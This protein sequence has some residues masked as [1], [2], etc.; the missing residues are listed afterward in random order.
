[1]VMDSE[2]LITVLHQVLDS[3]ITSRMALSVD[4][5]QHFKETEKSVCFSK[6]ICSAR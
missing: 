5:S 4:N 1:M 6:F 2:Y 3:K